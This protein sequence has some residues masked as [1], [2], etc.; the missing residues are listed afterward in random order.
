MDDDNDPGRWCPLSRTIPGDFL[1]AVDVWPSPE[2][3]ALE[4]DATAI[5]HNL[6]LLEGF[7]PSVD[8][9]N[10]NMRG[11]SEFHPDYDWLLRYAAELRRMR[12]A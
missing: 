7:N 10:I 12:D 4:T 11:R 6:R 3:A 9:A 5:E 1:L 2:K 8:R